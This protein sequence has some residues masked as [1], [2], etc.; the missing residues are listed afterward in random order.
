MIP[1]SQVVKLASVE[2]LDIVPMTM[3]LYR[4]PQESKTL[5]KYPKN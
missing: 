4:P 5:P 2:L 3:V 1:V